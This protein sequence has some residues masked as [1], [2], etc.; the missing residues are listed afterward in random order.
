[1]TRYGLRLAVYL[2]ALA[3][4]STRT[5]VFG[6]VLSNPLTATC[7]FVS[8]LP[9]ARMYI[10]TKRSRIFAQSNNDGEST[11]SS[12]RVKFSNDF[13]TTGGDDS[14]S[15]LQNP[16]DK[17]LTLVSSDAFSIVS[18]M[19]GLLAVVAYRWNLV[20]AADPSR[21]TAEA[22]TYETRTDLLGVL[23]AGSVL[24]NG[25]TKLDVTAALAES[26]VL[27]GKSLLEPEQVGGDNAKSGNILTWALESILAA[28][29]AKTAVLVSDTGGRWEVE[30]RAGIVPSSPSSLSLPEK[31][32]ILERV[33]SPGNSKETYLPTLQA[34]PGRTE[35]TYLPNNTQMAVMIPILP[36]SSSSSSSKNSVLVLGG[37]TAKSFTP[38]DIAWSRIV[39]EKIGEEL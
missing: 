31:T 29:P 17:F 15:S 8:E 34:L 38:R 19:I 4:V 27:E 22:L 24:L 18:G 39:A 28:T 33:G 2:M 21:A 7:N 3:L 5:Y 32:P 25:V 26:V 37:N 6:F 13:K 16:L 23:A 35:L 30:C 10:R 14:S 20:L 11:P 1:M 12:P 36:S 9:S